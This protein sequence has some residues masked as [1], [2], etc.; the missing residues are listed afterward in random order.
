MGGFSARDVA[1]GMGDTFGERI[2]RAT[3]QTA[4][5]T[6][7]IADAARDGELVFGS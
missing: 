1:R 3:E 4:K 2:A 5:S 6:K 7:E